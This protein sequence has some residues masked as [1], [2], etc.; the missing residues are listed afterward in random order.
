MS[1]YCIYLT[2]NPLNIYLPGGSM[3]RVP[4]LLLQD[5]DRP[6]TS[7]L[8]GLEITV[9]RRGGVEGGGGEGI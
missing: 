8:V 7:G 6:I 2:F 3:E 4:M 5:Q 9:R 1:I